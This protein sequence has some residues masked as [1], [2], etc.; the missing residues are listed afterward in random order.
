MVGNDIIDIF[1]TKRI[2]SSTVG[3]E[4]PG[5]VEKIFSSEEQ[6]MISNSQDPFSTVWRL[7]SMK[8]SAYKVYIQNGGE[9]CY[10]PSKILCFIE[11]SNLGNV[12][13]NGLILK[14][15]TVKNED[16]IFS[17]AITSNSEIKSKIIQLPD[18]DISKQSTFIRKQLL[19][20]Y[21]TS[22]LLKYE[23]LSIQK[24][25]SGVPKI[26][27]QNKPQNISISITHHGKYGAYSIL[28]N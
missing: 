11:N 8:E 10:N 24:L 22:Y 4:R 28:K 17:T 20:D 19:I 12:S 9:R 1:E 5:F 15:I 6:T 3:W 27:F 25:V 21:A 16:Y 14:T 13:F 23:D 2:S 7:W 26:Y 18:F